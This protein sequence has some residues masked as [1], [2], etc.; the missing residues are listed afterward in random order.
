MT[1]LQNQSDAFARRSP[2][3]LWGWAMLLVVLFCAA[4]T[5]G[6]PGTRVVGSAFD[7]ATNAVALNVKQPK[8]GGV[9]TARKSPRWNPPAKLPVGADA[10]APVAPAP[11][12]AAFAET[13]R[14]APVRAPVRTAALER[15]LTRPLGTR[16]P[17]RI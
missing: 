13:V 16:A 3:P 7:P 11:P 14:P 15:R 9:A 8:I 4:P 6:Q 17:P 12:A 10:A 5:G 1:A 2:F